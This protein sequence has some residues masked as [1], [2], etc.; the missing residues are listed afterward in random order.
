MLRQQLQYDSKVASER[1]G[2]YGCGQSVT[3]VPLTVFVV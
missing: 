1:I 3:V 2:L